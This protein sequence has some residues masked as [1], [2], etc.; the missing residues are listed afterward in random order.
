MRYFKYHW[1]ESRGD[2]HD[3][4]GTPW[5]YIEVA[6][7]GYVERQVEQYASG[8][9][10]TYDRAYIEDEFGGLAE[11]PIE[12]EDW[13]VLQPFSAPEFEAVWSSARP[14]NRRGG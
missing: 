11:K 14:L 1:N 2:A 4:W 10:L 13:R 8:A 3:D 5:W 12:P 6:D 7:D 9:C